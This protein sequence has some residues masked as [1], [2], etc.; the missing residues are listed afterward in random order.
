M[1]A[2]SSSTITRTR[3]GR[4]STAR[5]STSGG[6]SC[7]PARIAAIFVWSHPLLAARQRRPQRRGG[8]AVDRRSRGRPAGLHDRLLPGRRPGGGLSIGGMRPAAAIAGTRAKSAWTA[9]PCGAYRQRARID[10][11]P[12][13]V[14]GHHRHGPRPRGRPAVDHS[15]GGRAGRLVLVGPAAR[16]TALQG[17]AY[18]RGRGLRRGRCRSLRSIRFVV[19]PTGR[20]TA[21]PR[22]EPPVERTAF[23]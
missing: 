19:D 21:L 11:G 18:P 4:I 9:G 13:L 17:R 2:W 12:H 1:A 22:V 14:R 6:R 10:P 8:H 5:G 15:R 16:R 7:R 3:S 23:W 20:Y